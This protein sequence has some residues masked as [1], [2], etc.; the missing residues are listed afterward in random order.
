M[1]QG[2]VPGIWVP[3]SPRDWGLAG[4]TEC[5]EGWGALHC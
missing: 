3:V 4:N 5:R 2:Q 1:Q